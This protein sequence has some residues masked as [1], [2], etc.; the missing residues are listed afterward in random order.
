V[1]DIALARS[2]EGFVLGSEVPP[3]RS[4][5][6]L[7]GSKDELNFHWQALSAVAQIVQEPDFGK[8]WLVAHSGQ[9]LRDLVLLGERKRH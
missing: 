2:Q 9:G 1:F 6:V 8:R 4:V 5:F 3:V 7:V